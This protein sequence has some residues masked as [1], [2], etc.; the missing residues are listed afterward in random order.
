MS[1]FCFDD[2]VCHA[3]D[4][5]GEGDSEEVVSVYRMVN[6]TKDATNMEPLLYLYSVSISYQIEQRP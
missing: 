3:R 1:D 5:I 4:V 2:E 6:G